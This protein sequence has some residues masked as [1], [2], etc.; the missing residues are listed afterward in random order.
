[1]SLMGVD[2]GTTGCKAMVISSEGEVRAFSYREY[3]LIHPKP[4]WAE[5]DP[6]VVWSGIVQ[7]IGEA[8]AGSTHDPV[9]ALGVSVQGEATVP[10]NRDG[11]HIHNFV[12]TFDERTTEQCA[13][14]ERS[15]GRERLF[16]ITGMPL[17]P[18][19]SINKIIWFVQNMPDLLEHAWKF[20]CM[21]D[22]VLMKLGVEP[23][24]DYSLAA[25]TMAFALN[26]Y[27]LFSLTLKP[28][29]AETLFGSLASL[30]SLTMKTLSKWFWSTP[31]AF[32]FSTSAFLAASATIAL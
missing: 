12:V 3:P 2:V 22:Y 10:V 9:R 26:M 8:A 7:V 11:D 5:L 31:V 24:I 25:R 16:E 17:H 6:A 23:T 15:V 27:S 29:A 13:W 1:M 19:Y 4:G 20:L 14:W 32:W 28:T 18:M 21:E 30:K